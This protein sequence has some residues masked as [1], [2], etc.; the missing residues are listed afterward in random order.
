MC[1]TNNLLHRE[2]LG[3]CYEAK[4]RDK[5][6]LNGKHFKL[7]RFEFT[8]DV[9]SGQ[10]ISKYSRQSFTVQYITNYY[11]PLCYSFVHAAS[12][13]CTDK[14]LGFSYWSY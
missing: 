14:S 10:I 13:T 8:E 11:E 3:K 12:S 5:R 2:T 4:R 9:P 6:R 7:V 1:Y